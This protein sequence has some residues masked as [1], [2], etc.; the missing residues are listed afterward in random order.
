MHRRDPNL[1]SRVFSKQAKRLILSLCFQGH[2]CQNSSG[3][4]HEMKML[5]VVTHEIRLA[6]LQ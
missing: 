4:C 3:V 6:D 5:G 1:K 2:L